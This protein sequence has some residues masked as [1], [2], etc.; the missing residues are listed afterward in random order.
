MFSEST[1]IEIATIN[2]DGVRL[3]ASRNTVLLDCTLQPS[4]TQVSLRLLTPYLG[5]GFGLI[6][7]PR[8]GDEVVALFPG[9]A[10]DAG[11]ALWGAFN[12]IDKVP[13]GALPDLI[14][15]EGRPGDS[16]RVHVRGAVT[17]EIDLDLETVVHGAERRTVDGARATVIGGDDS[18]TVAGNRASTVAGNDTTTVSGNQASTITGNRADAVAGNHQESIAGLRITNIAGAWTLTI[19]GGL[20]LIAPLLDYGP[21]A[22]QI[23]PSGATFN[24][25]VVFTAGTTGDQT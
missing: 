6:A 15:L 9:G 23:T 4:G 2:P 7:F 17:V 1:C 11:Y 8:A 21:G 3:L 16:V 12:G 5:M 20:Q 22:F 10:L 18:L 13:D 14:L 24:V 19:A 25:P